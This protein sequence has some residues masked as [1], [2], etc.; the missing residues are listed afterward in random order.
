M[1][2]DLPP[3][4]KP[5]QV[6]IFSDRYHDN[7]QNRFN[8]WSKDNEGKVHLHRIHSEVTGAGNSIVY[9]IWCFYTESLL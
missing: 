7:I 2:G 4:I 3:V 1:I 8:K 5:F 6:L 9:T